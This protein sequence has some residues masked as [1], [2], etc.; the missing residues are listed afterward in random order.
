M[1]GCK[2]TYNKA[3]V[4]AALLLLF[5]LDCLLV[6]LQN[7]SRKLSP[8]DMGVCKFVVPLSLVNMKCQM[9]QKSPM[10]MNEPLFITNQPCEPMVEINSP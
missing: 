8:S 9:S 3:K 1:Y 6:P 5:G 2:G 4:F 10:L 7:C